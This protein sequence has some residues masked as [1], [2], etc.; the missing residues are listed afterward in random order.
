MPTRGKLEANIEIK[1]NADKYWGAIRDFATVFPKAFPNDIKSIEIVEG[2]GKAVGSVYHIITGGEGSPFAKTLVEKIE[3]VD[4]AKKMMV[5]DTAAIE[6][7]VLPHCKSFKEHVTV[8]PKG[9]GSSLLK[10]VGEY[11]KPNKEDP[12]PTILKDLELHTY[13]V[14]DAYIQ[15]A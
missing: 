2:D 9:D 12:V 5:I 7:D 11:E 10:W 15:N 1:S 4:D 13:Q 8:I 14:L 6:G 3:I